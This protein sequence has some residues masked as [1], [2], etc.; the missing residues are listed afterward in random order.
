MT[1]T[2]D[3]VDI[4]QL[5]ADFF[6]YHRKNNNRLHVPGTFRVRN[7]RFVLCMIKNVLSYATIDMENDT[8]TIDFVNQN[9]PGKGEL[10]ALEIKLRSHEVCIHC[11]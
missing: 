10:S 6:F 11:P 4:D 7:G 2:S 8:S 1:T 3:S 9:E 5:S